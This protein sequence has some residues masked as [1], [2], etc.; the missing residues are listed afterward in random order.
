MELDGLRM[1]DDENDEDDA[2]FQYMIEQSLLESS[3]KKEVPQ[4]PPTGPTDRSGRKTVPVS[5]GSVCVSV[6]VCPGNL[7]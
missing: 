4:E 2:A 3:K 7:E 5:S 6:C 1:E